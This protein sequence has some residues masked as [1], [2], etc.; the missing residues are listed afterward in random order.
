MRGMWISGEKRIQVDGIFKKKTKR[1]LFHNQTTHSEEATLWLSLITS[2]TVAFAFIFSFVG[3]WVTERFKKGIKFYFFSWLWQIWKKTCHSCGLS[4]LHGWFYCNGSVTKQSGEEN[5]MVAGKSNMFLG[6]TS[7]S[8]CGGDG[9]RHGQYVHPRLHGR[10][11]SCRV[12]GILGSLFSGQV[13][14]LSLT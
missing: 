11:Q 3:G 7:G 14:T 13:S 6:A 2:I 9:H 8:D 4:G 10:D 5:L 1:E 12:E